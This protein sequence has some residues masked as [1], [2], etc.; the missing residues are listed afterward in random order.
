VFDH[1]FMRESHLTVGRA[2]RRGRGDDV[3]GVAGTVD[4]RGRARWDENGG[5]Q[6]GHGWA[7]MWNI[8]GKGGGQVVDAKRTVG[9]KSW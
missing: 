7:V 3:G 6:A 1:L 5:R 9:W 2:V 4:R 8:T